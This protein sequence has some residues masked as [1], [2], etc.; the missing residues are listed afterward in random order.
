MTLGEADEIKTNAHGFRAL[1]IKR[2][3]SNDI[4]FCYSVAALCAL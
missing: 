1:C 2:A 4:L 3:R